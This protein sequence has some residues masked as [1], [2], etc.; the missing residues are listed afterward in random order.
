MPQQPRKTTKP[1]SR[2]S[3]SSSAR[4]PR[5]LRDLDTPDPSRVKGG[6]TATSTTTVTGS[7]T[8]LSGIRITKTIVPCV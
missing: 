4:S 1:T 8:S 6:F 2:Q 7:S 5:K 3:T